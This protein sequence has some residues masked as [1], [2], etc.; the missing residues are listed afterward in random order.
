MKVGFVFDRQTGSHAVY[1]RESDKARIVIPMHTG[2]IIKPKTLAG[3]VEDM[4]L[5]MEE[6]RNLLC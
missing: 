4:G 2:K 1:Y 5:T 6:L 3:I